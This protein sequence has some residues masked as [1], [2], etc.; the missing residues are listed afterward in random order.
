[1]RIAYLAFI[2]LD[3]PNACVSHTREISEQ[4]AALGHEVTVILPR[5]LRMQTWRGVRQVWVR[6]WGFDRMRQWAFFLESAWH[7]WRLHR[8]QGFDLLY[9]REMHRHPFLP[10]LVQVLGLPLF[11]EVNGWLRDDLRMTGASRRELRVTERSQR[12]LFTA[13]AGVLVVT[14]SIAQQIMRHYAIGEPRLFVQEVGSNVEHFAPWEGARA[15]SRSVLDLPRDGGIVLFAGSFHPHHDLDTLV[16]A[17]AHVSGE[18]PGYLLL[19]VGHGMQWPGIR[20]RITSLGVAQQVKMPGARPYEEMPSYFQAADV[21]VLPVIAAT[22][23]RRNGAFATKLW[24]YMASSLPVVVTDF[25]DT[26]SARLLADKVVVVP[27]EDAQAMA[28]ALRDLLRDSG[29]RAAL[30]AAGRRY[31]L[32]HRT[33][34][35]A[36]METADFIERRLRETA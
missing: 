10:L 23:R 4:L 14:V 13:A 18:D 26:A 1:M 16:R 6:W 12:R 15:Q 25:P 30:G 35:R 34:R 29:K 31:V 7:L 3:V 17:F 21:A 11:V 36:A 5:P 32:Q 9:V 22:I 20:D 33:W 19:L 28:E 8:R 27:P 2:E 24:D